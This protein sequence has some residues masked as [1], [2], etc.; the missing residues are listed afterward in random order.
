MI[1]ICSEA[2]DS[3]APA[4]ARIFAGAGPVVPLVPRSTTG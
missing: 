1:G 4:G 2:D 3:R